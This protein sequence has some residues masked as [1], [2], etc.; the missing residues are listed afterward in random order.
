MEAEGTLLPLLLQCYINTDIQFLMYPYSKMMAF[1]K[2]I[3]RGDR[4][5]VLPWPKLPN[6]SVLK[7]SQNVH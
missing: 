5:A 6:N 1:I 4:K 3:T 7:L 2:C